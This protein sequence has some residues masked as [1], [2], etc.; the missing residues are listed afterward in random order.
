M[1]FFVR[2]LDKPPFQ[3]LFIQMYADMLLRL[4]KRLCSSRLGVRVW[5]RAVE[6][7]AG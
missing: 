3:S 5:E 7:V 6:E 2:S 1:L 4:Q